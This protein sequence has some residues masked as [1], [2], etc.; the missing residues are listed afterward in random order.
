MTM[1]RGQVG[2]TERAVLFL[3]EFFYRRLSNKI[4]VILLFSTDRLIFVA[5]DARL[6]GD[7]FRQGLFNFNAQLDKTPGLTD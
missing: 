1:F 2:I 7:R 5:I 4:R 6:A 3:D